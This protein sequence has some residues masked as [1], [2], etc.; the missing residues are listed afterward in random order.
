MR[1]R[2]Y[3][4][5]DKE[6][7]MQLLMMGL[8]VI[9][10]EDQEFLF[11]K[12]NKI[13]VFDLENVGVVGF[14]SFGR[15]GKQKENGKLFLY[16]GQEYRRRKIGTALHQAIMAYAKPFQLNVIETVFRID[17][18]DATEYFSKLGYRKW[19]GLHVMSYHG[20]MQPRSNMEI[21][22]YEDRFYESYVEEIR[23]S[24]YEMRQV[25]D[26]KPY[27]CVEFSEKQRKELIQD[28][29]HLY[30]LLVDGKFAASAAVHT[31]LTDVC[32]PI[33]VASAYQGKGYGKIITQF[34]MNEALHRG[35]KS[36]TLEVVEWNERAVNL[37]KSLGFEIIQTTNSFRL[38]LK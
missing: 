8:T 28:K 4:D 34:V 23:K 11:C 22:P 14:C 5:S 26:F 6:R 21:V 32:G 33:F 18:N 9:N 36:I 17:Q 16:V 3:R 1:I 37:Y 31:E 24:F 25:N 30:V 35:M 10:E 27:N 2:E 7:M 19:Y 29:E 15:W 38:F 12:E 20:G 13:L